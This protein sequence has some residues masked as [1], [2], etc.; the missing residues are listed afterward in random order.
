MKFM[1]YV[2]SFTLCQLHS[3][4]RRVSLLSSPSIMRAWQKSCVIWAIWMI[5][6]L[7]LLQY[8]LLCGNTREKLSP[9]HSIHFLYI[10][11]IDMCYYKISWNGQ[12][13][14][15]YTTAPWVN[16]GNDVKSEIIPKHQCAG[17]E[18]ILIFSL[19]SLLQ[20]LFQNEGNVPFTQH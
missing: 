15:I 5:L 13:D 9:G 20:L 2:S 17:K 12:I 6:A 19:K 14:R 11:Y 16:E 4:G 7:I 8:I 1:Y 3:P 10:L 18:T